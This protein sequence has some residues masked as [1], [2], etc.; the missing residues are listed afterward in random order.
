[1]NYIDKEDNGSYRPEELS[2]LK[3]DRVP[4]HIAIIMDGNRRWAK[5]HHVPRF[6]GHW[7][8]AENITRVVR[9]AKHLGVKIITVFAFSTENWNRSKEEV[10]DLMEIF[11]RF[12]KD[13]RD[14]LKQEG[15]FL[16]SIGDLSHMPIQVQQAFEDTKK[17]T[18][19]CTSIKLVLAMNYGGRDDIRRAALKLMR[20]YK[21]GAVSLE[22]V[23]EELFSSYLDTREIPDP[24][25]FIRPSGEKR[26]SNFL[27]WQ[28]AYTEIYVTDVLWPDF[29]HK[30]LLKAVIDYQHRERR[31]G[32]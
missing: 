15:V 8:G 10:D 14:H 9:A 7:K 3:K 30:Q 2:E 29:D 16:D 19:A 1:M 17:A 24:D 13:K 5:M 12:L 25:L 11:E 23:T 22:S 26:I 4:E 31:L 6:V 20:D 32:G 21:E 27:L 28:F 18:E